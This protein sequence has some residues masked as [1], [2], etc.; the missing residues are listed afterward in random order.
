VLQEQIQALQRE[1][2]LL[3][4]DKNYLEM[5]VRQE[6]GLVKPGEVV[7]EFE[8]KP[9][10]QTMAPVTPFKKSAVD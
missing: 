8:K 9:S 5:V 3:Q 10:S 7:Y 6:M 1:K 4:N 2:Q